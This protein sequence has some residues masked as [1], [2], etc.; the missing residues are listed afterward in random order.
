MTFTIIV[1][2]SA[3]DDIKW[4]KVFEQRIILNAIRTHL[5]GSP[6]VENNRR[7]KLRPNP[8]A[9]WELKDGDYRVFYSVEEHQVRILAVGYKV[10]N[11]LHIRGEEVI[12]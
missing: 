11:Q 6:D 8:I 7:K 5:H 9:P 2:P 3:Q 4:F 12:L 1:T 10:H